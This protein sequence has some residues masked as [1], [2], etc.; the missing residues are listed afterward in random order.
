M[1]K[2]LVLRV[3]SVALLLAVCLGG[4][5]NVSAA[6]G[7]GDHYGTV[8]DDLDN[9]NAQPAQSNVSEF[10]KTKLLADDFTHLTG[11]YGKVTALNG[12]ITVGQETIL[13]AVPQDEDYTFSH[14]EN[15][16]GEEISKNVAI[17][18]TFKKDEKL[19]A[20]FSTD[21]V[22]DITFE[23]GKYTPRTA[24]YMSL[25]TENDNTFMS[26]HPDRSWAITK[27]WYNGDTDLYESTHYKPNTTYKMSFDYFIKDPGDVPIDIFG[28]SAH[29]SLYDGDA[30]ANRFGANDEN[31]AGWVHY[32]QYFKTDEQTG[33]GYSYV[34]D[35]MFQIC[36]SKNFV[37]WVDNLRLG[38][39]DTA[40][41]EPYDNPETVGQYEAADD[42]VVLPKG[43]PA[44][45]AR[46]LFHDAPSA[47]VTKGGRAVSGGTPVTTGMTLI[48]GDTVK[49]VAVKG[50]LTGDGKTTVSDI[51]S[52]I[53]LVLN[54]RKSVSAALDVNS[55][56]RNTVTD[57]V[58]MRKMVL[59]GDP[60][61]YKN[62]DCKKPAT[63]YPISTRLQYIR[64][65]GR[66]SNSINSLGGVTFD[67]AGMSVQFA[68]YCE[69]TVR[70]Q[71]GPTVG[72][73]H[74]T[75][76]V[77]GKRLEKDI[78]GSGY[79][80]LAT[81][82]ERGYHTFELAKGTDVGYYTTLE[83]I[84]L[85]GT[86]LP[87][88]PTDMPSIEFIG[89]S[90]TS[91]I[92]ACYKEG[93]S[94]YNDAT[95]SYGFLTAHELGAPYSIF[96][97]GG[98]SLT[99]VAKDK[100]CIKD[101]YDRQN[102]WRPYSANALYDFKGGSDIVVINLGTNDRWS[103][104]VNDEQFKSGMYYF[105]DIVRKKNPNAKIVW[106]YG[107]MFAGDMSYQNVIEEVMTDLG[108]TAK[109]YYSCELPYDWGTDY[110]YTDKDGKTVTVPSVSK[111]PHFANHPVKEGHEAAAK[112][113]AQFLRENVIK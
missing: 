5:S 54:D 36:S 83:S 52:G 80:T 57:L 4:F 72:K 47:R 15:A 42:T 59:L 2:R 48:S 112:V 102:P 105:L 38:I 94:L 9:P 98:Y 113:L 64:L 67:F 3:L 75:A 58:N 14:W 33:M 111:E 45:A 70:V 6:G 23:N 104:T 108:G 39:V 68:A 97:R 44:A 61:E 24:Q 8:D 99:D 86:I 87:L 34:A 81:D 51:I 22:W 26:Y 79:L 66:Y 106:V 100:P 11:E 107:M 55:D 77:D 20:V 41:F 89:D 50:D 93:V 110:T 46:M 17:R 53:D 65:N 91:G 10:V 29:K 92:G 101:I 84:S 78:V 73:I 7:F 96:S 109:G 103:G 49:T 62:E 30:P 56:G 37:V 13:K 69:G 82:L 71:V 90:I 21:L 16:N 32:E 18:Y 88:D 31:T 40:R 76:F 19:T 28:A 35:G 25:E 74:Y 60:D 12:K 95:L 43:M 27:I 1:K 63:D 85:S